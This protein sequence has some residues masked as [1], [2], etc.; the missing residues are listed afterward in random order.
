MTGFG[1]FCFLGGIVVMIAGVITGIAMGDWSVFWS[2]FALMIFP[3]AFLLACASV[4]P[5]PR[6]RRQSRNYW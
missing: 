5:Q 2:G 1:L 3:G 4:P 6:Q